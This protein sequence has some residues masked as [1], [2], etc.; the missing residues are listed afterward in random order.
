MYRTTAA[1][2][3]SAVAFSLVAATGLSAQ[4]D[5]RSTEMAETYVTPDGYGRG[6]IVPGTI[7][8]VVQRA[9]TVMIRM[10]VVEEPGRRLGHGWREL[11]GK[12]GNL[13][14]QIRIKSQSASTTRV[15]VT[16]R[17]GLAQYDQGTAQRLIDAIR[18]T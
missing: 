16:A 8:D 14:V 3:A 9:R 6:S 1:Q 4:A 18:K 17:Q 2:F 11:R 15:E 13:D 10:K 5:Q 7:N 12:T